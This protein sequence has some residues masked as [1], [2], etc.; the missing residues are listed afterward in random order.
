VAT[1]ELDVLQVTVLSVALLGTTVAVSVSDAPGSR[2]SSLLLKETDV[3]GI[4]V[5]LGS[6]LGSG[7]GVLPQAKDRA[8]AAEARIRVRSLIAISEG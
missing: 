2:V 1:P 6:G 8:S 4:V 7:S 5:G 3:T